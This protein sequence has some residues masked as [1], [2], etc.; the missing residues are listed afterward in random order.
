MTDPIKFEALRT[1][2]AAAQSALYCA[3]YSTPNLT[4]PEDLTDY[5]QNL[6][7]AR[8]ALQTAWRALDKRLSS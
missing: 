6:L 4:L 3:L 8:V 7:A 5:R 2:I 1:Q